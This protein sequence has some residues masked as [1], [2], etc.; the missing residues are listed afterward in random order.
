M[1]QKFPVMLLKGLILLP[2]QEVKIELNNELSKSVTSLANAEY[3]RHLLVITPKNLVEETPEVSDLPEV[4]V[5]GKIKSRIELPN[6]NVRVTIKGIERVKILEFSNNNEN[7]DILEVEVAK[8]D[9]PDFD[10]VEKKANIQKL[11][12]LVTDYVSAS[13]HISNSIINHIKTI[14]NLD[15]LTD[16][17]CAFLPISFNKKLEYI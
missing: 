15:R 16:A 17:I 12:A 14:D 8:I 3:N 2:N 5:I 10:E 1:Q 4:G 13:N 6:G 7:S 11:I 9:L